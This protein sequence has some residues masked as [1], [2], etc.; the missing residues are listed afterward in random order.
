M[1]NFNNCLYNAALIGFFEG[2]L[3]GRK[4]SSSTPASYL[5]LKNAAVAFAGRV[6]AA[7]PFDPTITTAAADPTML[8]DTASQT[9]QS[10]TQMKPALLQGIC[11]GVMAGSYTED[12]V[13]ADYTNLANAAAAAYSQALTGLVSP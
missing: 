10:N 8:V 12:A 6:D 4:V 13:A 2:V 7:I 9:I 3:S 5:A 11:A 1:A